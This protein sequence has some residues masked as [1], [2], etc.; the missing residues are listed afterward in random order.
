M[1]RK[2]LDTPRQTGFDPLRNRPIFG[3]RNVAQ[4]RRCCFELG[5]HLALRL[6]L[7]SRPK[8]FR[9]FDPSLFPNLMGRGRI[10]PMLLYDAA[11]RLLD[12][13]LDVPPAPARLGDLGE[14]LEQRLGV[15]LQ[16][17]QLSLVRLHFPPGYSRRQLVR[18][19]P[20]GRV[21]IGAHQSHRV[22]VAA[23]AVVAVEQLAG[24]Q[25]FI[26]LRNLPQLRRDRH[27]GQDAEL[28]R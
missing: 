25:G 9:G 21:G 16:R 5:V 6:C 14:R 2:N 19:D 27:V 17:L 10:G 22:E 15:G 18:I 20:F 13:L 4:P 24:V 23:D 7:K 3:F 12:Q 8:L 26:G 1:L 11:R 28:E